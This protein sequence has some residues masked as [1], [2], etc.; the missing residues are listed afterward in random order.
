MADRIERIQKLIAAGGEDAFLTYSLGMELA[1]A[2]RIDE[3][4]A[5]FR[6]CLEL[7]PVYIPACTEAG[8]ALRSAG[9]LAE[10]RAM[11][12]AGLDLAVKKGESHTDYSQNRH[13]QR[14]RR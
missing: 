6:R 14:N 5:Q 11:F 7:D 13:D 3:A 8:K 4:V 2:G 1:S 12:Q 9:R 10:A